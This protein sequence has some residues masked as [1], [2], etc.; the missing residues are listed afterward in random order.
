MK[1]IA[2]SPKRRDELSTLPSRSPVAFIISLPFRWFP[3]SEPE[4]HSLISTSSSWLA[5][6]AVEAGRVSAL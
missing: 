2:S 1:L 4:I 5:G 3:A 6:F